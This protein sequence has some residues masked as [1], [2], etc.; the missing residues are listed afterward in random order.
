MAQVITNNRIEFD[1]MS[2]RKEVLAELA[3]SR[4]DKEIDY[5]LLLE[6]VAV[7]LNDVV[8]GAKVPDARANRLNNIS[9]R[10][11][12]LRAKEKSLKDRI[13]AGSVVDEH[14]ESE[15]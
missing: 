13:E 10:I 5:K 9:T 14:A 15:W 3:R 7:T 6:L 11:A 2:K 1:G 8:Q 4:L 12:Q